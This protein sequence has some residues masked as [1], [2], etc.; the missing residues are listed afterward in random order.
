MDF[1]VA[2]SL[3]AEKEFKAMGYPGPKIVCIPNGVLISSANKSTYGEVVRVLA[4]AR[5]DRQK[6]IDILIRAWGKAIQIKPI[7]KLIILGDGPQ[8]M[9]L[10]NL[11]RS[12]GITHSIEFKGIVRNVEAY[13]RDADLFVLPSRAEGLSNALLEAMSYGIPC[14]A[15]NVGGNSEAFGMNENKTIPH[16]EYALAKHGVLVNPDDADGLFEAILY[17]I[18][19]G[20]AREEIGRRSRIFIQENYSIDLIADKYINLYRRMMEGK[21]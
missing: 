8:A 5:L 21:S 20:R 17:L 1:L 16:G 2:L 15:T 13:L 6:G 12:L 11:V 10:K 9:E 7:P 18:R 19:D 14:I 3:E 4:I